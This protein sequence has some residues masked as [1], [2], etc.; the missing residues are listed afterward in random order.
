MKL[1]SL[2]GAEINALVAEKVFEYKKCQIHFNFL[3]WEGIGMIAE[4]MGKQFTLYRHVNGD[5]TASFGSFSNDPKQPGKR[6]KAKTPWL[7]VIL[8]AL[9]T[10]GVECEW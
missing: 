5:F 2:T 1:S 6:V 8:A 9:K 7:A 4:K 10:K 3:S